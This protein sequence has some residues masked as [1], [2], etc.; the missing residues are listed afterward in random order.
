MSEGRAL[1]FLLLTGFLTVSSILTAQQPD[2]ESSR[3]RLDD[4]RAERERL[5]REQDRLEG[6]VRDAGAELRNIE[7]QRDAT[8]RIVNELE[9]QMRGLGDQL[10]SSSQQLTLAQD[11]LA[12]RR[13]VLN[14]RLVEIYKR[15]PLFTF[16]VLLSAE[17]FGDLLSRYKYLYLQNRQ[18]RALVEDISRLAGRIRRQR[19]EL[20]DVQSDLDRRREER[21]S[22]LKSFEV[23]AQERF[24]RLNRLRRSSES[25]Q[26]RLS[27]LERDEARLNDVLAGLE[28]ARR[29]RGTLA[30]GTPGA[31][32][33]TTADLGSLDWPVS[34]RILFR[35]GRDT[36][37]SGAVIR[38]NGIAIGAPAGT[39]VKAV[40]SG[41]VAL[42]QRLG[43]YGL[44]V[45]LEHGNGYF[46]LYM[47]L[48]SASVAVGES[49]QRGQ[50]IGTVGGENTDQGPHLYFE[51]RGENQIALDPADWLRRR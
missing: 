4:I 41:R 11:N 38:R 21:A 18:D 36:L 40:S 27:V 39:P 45:V 3:R 35:F 16:Q 10:L 8:N 5:R 7:R 32:D 24:A 42:V 43:T 13:A 37:P 50:S 46:S 1:S 25:A 33:L 22:E 17:S 20:V 49:V 28:R 9:R 31:N 14:R 12:D 47:Q 44:T 48:G 34:G 51:I 26:Q 30:P 19:G 15:G 29:P 6:Q 2:I 23:L